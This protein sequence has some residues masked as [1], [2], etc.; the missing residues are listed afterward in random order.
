MG[1]PPPNAL[2]SRVVRHHYGEPRYGE[3]SGKVAGPN[4]SCLVQRGRSEGVKAVRNRRA[5]EAGLPPGATAPQRVGCVWMPITHV[6]TVAHA[7]HLLNHV[8]SHV[9][10]Y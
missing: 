2:Q 5:W 1:L 9:L 4:D 8:L 3:V 7:S 6:T 10:K